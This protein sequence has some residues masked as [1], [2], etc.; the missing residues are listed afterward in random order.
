[1]LRGEQRACRAPPL[2]RPALGTAHD[3]APGAGQQHARVRTA[4]PAGRRGEPPRRPVQ[5]RVIHLPSRTN[6]TSSTCS[7]RSASVRCSTKVHCRAQCTFAY[8]LTSAE[9]AAL[10][11]QRRPGAPAP[12]PMCPIRSLFHPM[13]LSWFGPLWPHGGPLWP[14]PGARPGATTRTG[15]GSRE[16]TWQRG[17]SSSARRCRCPPPPLVLSGHAASL[18]PY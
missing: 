3:T 18:T 15:S 9:R 14:H 11:P 2:P 7:A 16:T 17:A 5:P 4:A 6:W 10:P 8:Q 12:P 1:M 13:H